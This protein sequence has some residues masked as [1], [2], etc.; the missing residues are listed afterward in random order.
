MGA[1]NRI[2]QRTRPHLRPSWPNI[3]RFY[4]LDKSCRKLH[5]PA[6]RSS[7]TPPILNRDKKLHSARLC[8]VNPSNQRTTV[9]GKT[10]KCKTII[11]LD[12]RRVVP[13]VCI[14]GSALPFRKAFL[15]LHSIYFHHLNRHN[16]PNL[17]SGLRDRYSKH[18][19]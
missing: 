19:T 17:S 11:L 16:T 18:R 14:Q 10:S 9:F 8:G 2:R 15:T 7:G 3:L 6:R 1:N 13:Y 5:N 12:P 4:W